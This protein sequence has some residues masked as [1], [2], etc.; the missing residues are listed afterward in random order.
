MGQ[1]SRPYGVQDDI[2]ALSRPV[3]NHSAYAFG[4]VI[5]HTVCPR[6]SWRG[7]GQP[8]HVVVLGH[9]ITLI[10]DLFG[11]FRQPRGMSEGI[12]QSRTARHRGVVEYGEAEPSA[13]VTPHKCHLSPRFSRRYEPPVDMNQLGQSAHTF[14]SQRSPHRDAYH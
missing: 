7:S 6:D 11:E 14:R 4:L 9:P 2:N 3:S 1:G 13:G 12:T 10:A 5:N 8:R